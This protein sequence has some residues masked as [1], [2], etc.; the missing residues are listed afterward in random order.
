MHLEHEQFLKELE[1]KSA[2]VTPRGDVPPVDVGR[3]IRLVL[4]FSEKHVVSRLGRVT[5][6]MYSVTVTNYFL[7]KVFSNVIQVL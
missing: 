6:K 2:T 5:L 1:L 7:K 3:H 4:P